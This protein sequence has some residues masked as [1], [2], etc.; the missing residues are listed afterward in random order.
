MREGEC[1]D[2]NK[3]LLLYQIDAL[4]LYNGITEKIILADF[5]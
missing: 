3:S 2:S 1:F 4:K 5:W